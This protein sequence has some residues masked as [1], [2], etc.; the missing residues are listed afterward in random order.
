MIGET[1]REF[2]DNEVRPQS[3]EAMEKHAWEVARE[4]VKKGRRLG[5]LGSTIPEEYGGLGLDQTT[6]VVIAEMMGRAGGFGTTFG[7]RLVDRPAAAALFWLRRAEKEVDTEDRFGR[8]R[9]GLLPDRERLGLGRSGRKNVGEADRRRTALRP[10]RR[11]DVHLKR[12]LCGCVHRLCKGRRRE[13]KVLGVRRRAQRKLPPGCRR[14]QDGD[15]VVV[16]DAAH[17]V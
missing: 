13:G 5:L 9:F 4:L 14:A 3:A 7:A 2:V 6:S 10:Q 11:E 15:Q 16:D 17:F 12:Q 1:T 8:D